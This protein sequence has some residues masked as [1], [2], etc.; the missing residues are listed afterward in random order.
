M[1]KEKVAAVEAL[2]ARLPKIACKGLCY[3]SCGPITY[4]AIEAKRIEKKVHRLPL[5]DAN[6]TCTLLIN[7]RCAA[8][9][10]RPLVCRM[11]GLV[12]TMRCPHGCA[13]SRMLTREESFEFFA[14]IEKLSPLT[15]RSLAAVDW[16]NELRE[17]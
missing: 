16:V 8:Y 17:R 2:Y 7:Q 4:T 14:A 6:L 5:V 10:V 9:A 12:E 15:E 11:F 1:N 3:E 13:P